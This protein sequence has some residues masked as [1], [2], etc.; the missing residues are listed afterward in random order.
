MTLLL[1]NHHYNNYIR[2]LTLPQE[3]NVYFT[4]WS[5]IILHNCDDRGDLGIEILMSY[6][7]L[8]DFLLYSSVQ[9][10]PLIP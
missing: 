8:H 9:K 7:N 1:A 3:R 6:S 2:Q 5:S 10:H 4:P